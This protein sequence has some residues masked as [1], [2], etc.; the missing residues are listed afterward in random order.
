MENP[1]EGKPGGRRV[2]YPI[3]YD[4]SEVLGDLRVIPAALCS[5][6]GFVALALDLA[7]GYR[8]PEQEDAEDK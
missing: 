1:G 8:S 7:G 3:L 6:S 4:Y 2:P 5:K